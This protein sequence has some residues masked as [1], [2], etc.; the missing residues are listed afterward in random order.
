MS[1]SINIP[2]TKP[3]SEKEQERCQWFKGDEHLSL[4]KCGTATEYSKYCHGCLC[5]MALN[6]EN[7]QQMSQTIR[8]YLTEFP[9]EE[10]KQILHDFNEQYHEDIAYR[11]GDTLI[12]LIR[13]GDF[14]VKYARTVRIARDNIPWHPRAR[15][16]YERHENN[17]EL[18]GITPFSSSSGFSN[19]VIRVTDEQRTAFA[20]LMAKYNPK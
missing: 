16:V 9:N 2:V 18:L 12:S 3:Y 14:L 4:S 19:S 15:L 20:N 13:R 17:V 7:N 10:L 8:D 6:F 5:S 1:D 11:N